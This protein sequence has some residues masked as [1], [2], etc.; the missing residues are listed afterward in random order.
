MNSKFI[1]PYIPNFNPEQMTSMEIKDIPNRYIIRYKKGVDEK[2]GYVDNK[3]KKRNIKRTNYRRGKRGEKILHKSRYHMVEVDDVKDIIALEKDTDIQLVSPD[4]N[5]FMQA[6][7]NDEYFDLQWALDNKGLFDMEEGV[8]I[9][10]LDMWDIRKNVK[11]DVIVAVCDTGVNYNHPD[12]AGNMWVNPNPTFNDYHGVSI[13]PEGITGNCLPAYHPGKGYQ[14]HGTHVAGIIGAIGNNTIGV[15]GVA[16][17]CKIMALQVFYYYYLIEEIQGWTLRESDAILSWE[18]A[19]DFGAR[20][21]NNS[22]GGMGGYSEAMYAAFVDLYDAN[23]VVTC[24]A[25]N[26]SYGGKNNDVWGHSPSDIPVN[27]NVA[28]SAIGALGELAWYSNY[29]I[30]SVE[31]VAPGGSGLSDEMGYD[32]LSTISYIENEGTP[33]QTIKHGYAYAAGTSMAAPAIAGIAAL[34]ISEEELPHP[35]RF[36]Y[37]LRGSI[38]PRT[39]LFLTTTYGGYISGHQVLNQCKNYLP[40]VKRISL[41]PDLDDGT[42]FKI[43]WEN[44]TEP[45]FNKVIIQYSE[46]CFPGSEEEGVITHTL[47]QGTDEEFIHENINPSVV[48]GYKFVCVYAD[49]SMSIPVYYRGQL[50]TEFYCPNP[51]GPWDFRCDWWDEEWPQLV[52]SPL[53]QMNLYPMYWR[54]ISSKRRTREERQIYPSALFNF[55][56]KETPPEEMDGPYDYLIGTVPVLSDLLLY[57]SPKEVAMYIGQ[58]VDETRRLLQPIKLYSHKYKEDLCWKWLDY[59]H[60]IQ[61]RECRPYYPPKTFYEISWEDCKLKENW[62]TILHIVREVLNNLRVLYTGKPPYQFWVD[63]DESQSAT[64]SE[65][66]RSGESTTT[67]SYSRLVG[68]LPSDVDMPN[69]D[70]FLYNTTGYATSIYVDGKG[71][72]YIKDSGGDIYDDENR[73][74]HEMYNHIA[75]PDLKLYQPVDY[76]NGIYVVYNQD[77]PYVET[78]VENKYQYRK[79]CWYTY[80]NVNPPSIGTTGHLAN[81]PT[82]VVWLEGPNLTSY[83]YIPVRQNFIY[84]MITPTL[85]SDSMLRRQ[86]RSILSSPEGELQCLSATWDWEENPVDFNVYIRVTGSGGISHPETKMEN[87]LEQNAIPDIFPYD[88]FTGSLT[89]HY[90]T[91]VGDGSVTANPI[92]MYHVGPYVRYIGTFTIDDN[93][94]LTRE[95]ESWLQDM[96]LDSIPGT[97]LVKVHNSYHHVASGWWN[98]GAQ[99]YMVE[100]KAKWDFEEWNDM[101]VRQEHEIINRYVLCRA[102]SLICQVIVTANFE[103]CEPMEPVRVPELKGL[104]HSPG[105]LVDVL[106]EKEMKLGVARHTDYWEPKSFNCVVH[107]SPPPGVIYIKTPGN[108]DEEIPVDFTYSTTASED[109]DIIDNHY[110]DIPKVVGM[111]YDEAEEYLREHYGSWSLEGKQRIPQP[112][113]SVDIIDTNRYVITNDAYP[114]IIISQNPSWEIRRVHNAKSIRVAIAAGPT[115]GVMMPDI[116]GKDMD[117]IPEL[118]LPHVIIPVASKTIPLGTIVATVPAPL[119]LI[120]DTKTPQ[121]YICVAA[122]EFANTDKLHPNIIGYNHTQVGE[123]ASGY[124]I[125]NV[126]QNPSRYRKGQV[127][128]QIPHPGIKGETLPMN[129]MYITTSSGPPKNDDRATTRVKR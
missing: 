62:H 68:N 99:N 128:S 76:D 39:D 2:E 73:L 45:S 40:Q 29:G 9:D 31:C 57:Q 122:G 58:L 19:M 37:L 43:E 69:N 23:I 116:I 125:I 88:D 89:Y 24:A 6:L 127:I 60:Y 95:F 112:D 98:N 5:Y 110:Y 61:S 65:E 70:G 74:L 78:H 50:Q 54:C 63:H 17:K 38:K 105:E 28:V 8:D 20:V 108:D 47:Y 102:S 118:P 117:D 86:A 21:I 107:Q 126:G 79:N 13:T 103:D 55:Y 12:L 11:D 83:E 87:E 123:A 36:Q 30:K 66:L 67:V 124:T 101:G 42:K 96:G 71:Y 90:K 10:A 4:R 92:Q 77:K 80:W 93:N 18:Y 16:Q 27:N 33:S 59:Y 100:N 52:E 32:I 82:G 119:E 97:S 14:W 114:G 46:W 104:K 94:D 85:G 41:V 91:P 81:N 64:S 49:G 113:G 44:P 25:G 109:I 120:H 7:P 121:A 111:T 56:Q 72:P 106:E 53:L 3:F 15:T 26:N 34:S 75:L 22:W 48:Y 84:D 129:T 1:P 115:D 51:H 35:L